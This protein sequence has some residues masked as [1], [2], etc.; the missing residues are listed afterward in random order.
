MTHKETHKVRAYEVD[1]N[2]RLKLSSVFN[3]MQE[4]AANHAE[5]LQFGFDDLQS[6]GKI[7]AL[8]RAK[9]RLFGTLSFRDRIETETWPKG[10]DKL[11]ALRDFMLRSQN[12]ELIGRATS[13]WL[14]LDGA[15]MRPLRIGELIDHISKELPEPAMVEV[16]GKLT[17][18]ESRTSVMTRKIVYSDIDINSHTNNARYVEMV[19]DCLTDEETDSKTIDTMQINFLSES[20]LGETIRLMRAESESGEV[21]IEGIGEADEKVFQAKIEWKSK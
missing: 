6:Q 9:I 18:P 11:F 17:M 1:R 7:W 2:N 13:C 20:K 15:T 3:Y 16:P 21:F 12:G 8:S 5:S 10:I 4:T 14:M 19:T